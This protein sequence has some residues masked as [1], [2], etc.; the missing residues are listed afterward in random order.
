MHSVWKD[1]LV[2][3]KLPHSAKELF[4][5]KTPQSFSTHKKTSIILSFHSDLE[6]RQ[7]A[8][9]QIF[10]KMEI[11]GKV[12]QLFLSAVMEDKLLSKQKF[13]RASSGVLWLRSAWGLS[14][15]PGPVTKHLCDFC[16]T[17]PEGQQGE[18]KLAKVETVVCSLQI[19]I[20]PVLLLL[21]VTTLRKFLCFHEIL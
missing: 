2:L 19:H 10:F 15:L 18:A 16:W 11:L 4:L 3:T 17:A 1:R 21:T 20:Q 12:V 9:C 6:L 5:M 13:S 14:F 7:T 8:V